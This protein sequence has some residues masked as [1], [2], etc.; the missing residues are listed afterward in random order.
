MILSTSSP[1][2]RYGEYIITMIEITEES[3]KRSFEDLPIKPVILPRP[4]KTGTTIYGYNPVTETY[5][6]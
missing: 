5:Q 4:W 1:G 6:I 2:I 3:L